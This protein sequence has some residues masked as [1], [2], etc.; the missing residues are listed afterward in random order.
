MSD[1]QVMPAIVE[2]PSKVQSGLT[3]AQPPA[4]SQL[5]TAMSAMAGMGSLAQPG[6]GPM[7]PP[8]DVAAFL[9]DMPDMPSLGGEQPQP[10]QQP[11]APGSFQPQPPPAPLHAVAQEAAEQEPRVSKRRKAEASA[12][13]DDDDE[14][15]NREPAEVIA[16]A[17]GE[18][19][20]I[21]D[22]IE[23]GEVKRLPDL[24]DAVG[25]IAGE[26]SDALSAVLRLQE[27][28]MALMAEAAPSGGSGGNPLAAMLGMGMGQK[29]VPAA[30]SMSQEDASVLMQT[31]LVT[32]SLVRI[33][34]AQP[35]DWER[36][37]RAVPPEMKQVLVG[38]VQSAPQLV[39]A[40]AQ[41]IHKL[42][43]FSINDF[44]QQ[45][46]P[47]QLQQAQRMTGLDITKVPR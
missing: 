39:E 3:I 26:L 40:S 21:A 24:I 5:Q 11:M 28:A 17:A 6:P 16:D 37:L 45:I 31:A 19:G 30:P 25:A 41:I 36:Y 46:P 23:D 32:V 27:N 38:V 18:L 34:Q 9:A 2:I 12:D 4:P 44:M 8:A 1:E 22:E 7:S 35:K 10:Q 29:P 47:D 14:P 15:D 43:G 20:A 42:S 13:A 33:L